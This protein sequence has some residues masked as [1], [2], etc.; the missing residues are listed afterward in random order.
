MAPEVPRQSP[1]RSTSIQLT[2]CGGRGLAEDDVQAAGLGAISFCRRQAGAVAADVVDLDRA[3]HASVWP[4]PGHRAAD[5]P[6]LE[7][8]ST[9]A[10]GSPRQDSQ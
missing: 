7:L 1:S 10:R 8:T 2:R 9:R 6:A 4:A 3:S 5:E